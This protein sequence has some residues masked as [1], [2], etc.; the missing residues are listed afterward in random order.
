MSIFRGMEGWLAPSDARVFGASVQ[1]QNI[2][3]AN[4]TYRSRVSANSV[5]MREAACQGGSWRPSTSSST[6]VSTSARTISPPV[7]P[8]WL[9]AAARCRSCLPGAGPTLRLGQSVVRELRDLVHIGRRRGR[10]G[11]R[12]PTSWSLVSGLAALLAGSARYLRWGVLGRVCK[13]KPFPPMILR[14]SSGWRQVRL[15]LS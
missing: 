2:Y 8:S 13:F 4:I 5:L 10:S 6:L 1:I 14:L 15:F 9:P 11:Q 7:F 12:L 3:T